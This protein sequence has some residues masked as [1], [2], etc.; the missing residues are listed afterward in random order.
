MHWGAPSPRARRT[1]EAGVL[2]VVHDDGGGVEI[3]RF[4]EV[5][6]RR[7][8]FD[9][10]LPGGLGCDETG[11]P[12]LTPPAADGTRLLFFTITGPCSAG[13]GLVRVPV[14]ADGT[15][16]VPAVGLV[17]DPL[18]DPALVAGLP[19]S[20]SPSAIPVASTC[21]RPMGRWP[22][23]T[24]GSQFDPGELPAALAHIGTELFV[25]SRFAG[26]SRLRR[27]PWGDD[28]RLVRAYD[29]VPVGLAVEADRVLVATDAA[30]YVLDADL[31]TVST[32]R[33][34]GTA[35]AVS[36]DLAFQGGRAVSLIDGAVT[37]LPDADVAPALARG[38][39][40][41]GPL[42][43]ATSDVTPPALSSARGL[44]A[45]AAD[46]RGVAAVRFTVRRH[47][48]LARTDGSPWAP[49][50]YRAAVPARLA[51]GAYRVAVRAPT[52]PATS[53][54]PARG[55][56]SR[57]R[58]GAGA[59]ARR[60]A[61]AAARVATASTPAAAPTGS[62]SP[63]A[64]P[65][66]SAA[67]PAPTAS[68]P[69]V[70]TGSPRLRAHR[71]PAAV[72]LPV[73]SDGLPRAGFVLVVDDHDSVR[74]LLEEVLR[75]HDFE[76]TAVA[77]G[78]EALEA[79]EASVDAVLLDLG[80]PDMPGL[81]VLDRIRRREQ[82]PPVIVLTGSVDRDA[83]RLP[84]PRRARLHGQAAAARGAR[85]ARQRR[86]AGQAPAGPAAR[87]QRAALPSGPDGRADRP[88]QPPS[89]LPGARPLRRRRRYATTVSCAC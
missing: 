12:L 9:F 53:P 29:G 70:R 57:A 25:L 19:S 26:G 16:G 50:R 56:A 75:K 2:Y 84:E 36:G 10:A 64:A 24:P 52:S 8:G 61:C 47:R 39:V 32:V 85:R 6:G 31:G 62:W 37:P 51:P 34:D 68:A 1:A 23:P 82:A 69:T 78:R 60:S 63:A 35:P 40:V 45:T 33:G 20:P 77:T 13:E 30:L 66:G 74:H 58:A 89:R 87:R 71:P 67:E 28:G 81:D 18:G 11:A 79:I 49:A 7:L 76:V 73:V 72:I 43:L 17:A 27:V 48:L 42:A 55:C 5:T 86:G 3:A 38:F 21:S 44:A 41:F 80:L 22:S 83:P 15:L 88:C 14:E 65:T 46:D 59:A 4:D 54:P